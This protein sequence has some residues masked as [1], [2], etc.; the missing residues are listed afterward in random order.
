MKQI[1]DTV[2]SF[3]AFIVA[4]GLICLFSFIFLLASARLSNSTLGSLLAQ[5]AGETARM[6]RTESVS[7]WGQVG[8][9]VASGLGYGRQPLSTGGVNPVVT[10]IV[11]VATIAPSNGGSGSPAPT[12]TPLP[13]SFIRSSPY[14]EGGLF[15]WRGLDANG[16]GLPLGASLEQV[17][18]QAQFALNQNSGDLLGQWLVKMVN[19]C[20]PL[21]D[22]MVNAN[23]QDPTQAALIISAA[24][25]LIA[26]CNPRLY[27][28]YANKRWAQLSQ[29]V[30]QLPLDES[31]AT[32]LLTGLQIKIIGKIDGPAR[33]TRPEDHVQVMVQGLPEFGLAERSIVL[34]VATVD[35]LLGAGNWTLDGGP[36][37]VGTGTLFPSNAAEPTQ[38][39]EADL[40]PPVVNPGAGGGPSGPAAPVTN[41]GKY[42][43]QSGDT[44]Y[45]IARNFNIT[46]EALINANLNTVGFNP[47]FI[48]PG[49][50]LIIP[51]P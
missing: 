44:L 1:T 28:A 48:Q 7:F 19:N 26:Q 15:L 29:W 4:V 5:S 40:T 41:N 32:T 25:S 23:Y 37:P 43:I 38:P 8:G 21:Y 16:Q 49:Q 18:Q 46:P 42:V 11:I 31:Q 35:Q 17:L 12:A 50:E 24:D 27:A 34:S 22:Q 10:P 47:D 36:Y 2:N 30:S 3:V 45:S 14:S 9:E 51:T 33:A 39:S 20:R 6:A 13:T